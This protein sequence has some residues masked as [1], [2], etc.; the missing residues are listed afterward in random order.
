MVFLVLHGENNK[1]EK[2]RSLNSM[3]INWVTDKRLK[4]PLKNGITN[5]APSSLNTM[6]C[7]LFNAA[8]DYYQWQF[9]H[10]DFGF[11]GGYNRIFCALC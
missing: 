7:M 6:I 1:A 9:S 10:K 8:K 11:D 2:V 3:I 4:V 5:P